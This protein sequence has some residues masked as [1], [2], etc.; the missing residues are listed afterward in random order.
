MQKIVLINCFYGEFPWYFKFFIKTC[1][2]NPTINFLIFSDNNYIGDLPENVKI[3][4][5]SLEDFNELASK[6][7]NLKVAV[8][9]PYKLCDFKPAYGIIFSDYIFDYDFWGM[10]DLDIILGRV[11][12]FMTDEILDEYDVISTRHDFL[13]GW[14]MLFRNSKQINEL[15]LKSDDHRKVFT[16]ETH[17]C[18][19]E[20]N[21]KHLELEDQQVSILELPCE[22]DSMEHVV[23]RESSKGNIKV[24]YDLVMVD[25][26]CGKIKWN[27]GVLTYDNNFEILLYHLIRYKANSYSK[28][29]IWENIPNLFYIDKYVFR[30]KNIFSISGLWQYLYYNKLKLLFSKN[31]NLSKFYISNIF[32]K[33]TPIIFQNGVYKNQQG[34]DCIWLKENKL[35]FYKPKDIYNSLIMSKFSNNIYYMKNYKWLQCKYFSLNNNEASI[36]EI[37]QR[38]GSISSYKLKSININD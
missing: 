25:G 12:E 14:F 10:C 36:I 31:M 37:V 11:R 1:Y 22:I 16:T 27:N 4:S 24:F 38:D 9:A 20:C 35:S 6:K 7:L 23:Q 19:D 3:I 30:N 15:F 21:F 29:A 34:S 18:F 8:T 13:T 26:H 32:R 5:F 28:K 17:Y 2:T 33:N